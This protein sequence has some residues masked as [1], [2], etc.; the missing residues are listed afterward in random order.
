MEGRMTVSQILSVK[1]TQVVTLSP[2]ATIQNVAETLA[3]HRIGAVVI[4]D[5]RG[6]P[7]GIASERDIIRALS[8]QGAGALDQQV[9][10]IMTSNIKTCSRTDSETEIM[11]MMT[12]HR[13]RHLP[14]VEN[15]RLVGIVSIGDV[16]K[17][18][19]AAIEHETE[20]LR[21]YIATAG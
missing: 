20:D 21:S 9:Q 18:R 7:L 16:V 13:I 15:D 1:G 4:A 17:L 11:R 5:V 14:V 2:T 3:K 6:K 10:S 19:I 12:E 8:Q